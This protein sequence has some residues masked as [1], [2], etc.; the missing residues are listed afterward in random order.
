MAKNTEKITIKVEGEKWEKALDKSFKK[1]VKKR[2][3]DGFRKGMVPKEMYIQKFGIESLYQDAVD[4]ALNDA[5]KEAYEKRTV[6]PQVQ[7]SMDISQI[8]RDSVT[9]EFT[10]IGKPDVKLGEFKNLKIKKG[11]VEVT[12]EEIE[13]EIEHLRENFAEIREKEDGEVENGDTAVIDF[14]GEIDGETF[15]RACGQNYPL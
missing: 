8:D 15:D 6:E 9:F 3:V 14:K 1:N 13:H 12:D 7:P 10:F 11:K 2:P 5:Y 4:E